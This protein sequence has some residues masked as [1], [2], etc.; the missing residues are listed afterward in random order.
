MNLFTA[1]LI[2]SFAAIVLLCVWF[3]IDILKYRKRTPPHQV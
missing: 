2:F 3:F 1:I